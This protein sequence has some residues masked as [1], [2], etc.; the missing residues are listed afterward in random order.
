VFTALEGPLSD[1]FP[2]GDRIIPT[3]GATNS[4]LDVIWQ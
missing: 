1:P 3:T 2:S 4:P